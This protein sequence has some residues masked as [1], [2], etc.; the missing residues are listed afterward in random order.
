MGEK[1]EILYLR[2]SASRDLVLQPSTFQVEELLFPPLLQQKPGEHKHNAGTWINGVKLSLLK[3][4][5]E[6]LQGLHSAFV[7]VGDWEG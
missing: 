4:L 3:G 6:V 1:K 2:Y 7:R 5:W